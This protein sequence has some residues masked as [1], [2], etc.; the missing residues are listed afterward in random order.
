[1]DVAGETAL[2]V[3]TLSAVQAVGRICAWHAL[4]TRLSVTAVVEIMEAAWI[5]RRE[6]PVRADFDDFVRGQGLATAMSADRAWLHADTWEVQLRQRSVRELA[7]VQPRDAVRFVSDFIDVAGE[8]GLSELDEDDREVARV[9]GLPRKRRLAEMREMI[10]SRNARSRER[11]P[12][13]VAR[14]AELEAEQRDAVSRA[15]VVTHHPAMLVGEI[16]EAERR[17]ADIADRFAQWEEA[18][19]SATLPGSQASRAAIACDMAMGALER[20]ADTV[21][22]ASVPDGAA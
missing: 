17:L 12:D 11:H 20:I 10:R 22:I 18:R 3:A 4:L 8:E 6:Y 7:A 1:M 2:P 13:D 16:V 15:A 9:L 19:G 5:V 14:I 21:Q